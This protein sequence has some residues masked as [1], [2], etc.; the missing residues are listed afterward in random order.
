MS[1]NTSNT[2]N[3]VGDKREVKVERNVPNELIDKHIRAWAVQKD[4]NG[5]TIPG[6]EDTTI[7][8]VFGDPYFKDNTVNKEQNSE[9]AGA[10]SDTTV[11]ENQGSKDLDSVTNGLYIQTKPA[12]TLEQSKE[13]DKKK[14]TKS[15]KETEERD[16]DTSRE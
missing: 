1:N 5:N 3:G 13:S 9:E 14:S 15:A 10:S 12:P 2:S 16:D 7:K 4:K 8:V 11:M 6:T